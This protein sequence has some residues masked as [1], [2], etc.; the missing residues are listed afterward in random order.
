VSVER[1]TTPLGLAAEA[2]RWVG[3][4]LFNPIAAAMA[5]ELYFSTWSIDFDLEVCDGG[6]GLPDRPPGADES[7]GQGDSE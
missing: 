2:G 6:L 4:T 1:P 5:R 7:S 3:T